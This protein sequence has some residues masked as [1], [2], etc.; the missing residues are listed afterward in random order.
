MSPRPGDTLTAEPTAPGTI[1]QDRDGDRWTLTQPG[2]WHCPRGPWTRTWANLRE[3]SYGQTITLVSTPDPDPDPATAGQWEAITAD[4]VRPGDEVEVTREWD[5][6]RVV[7]TGRVTGIQEYQAWRMLS[8]DR[9]HV[10]VGDPEEWITET[11]RRRVR[12]P[13]PE[14][15]A[16]AVVRHAGHVLVRPDGSLGRDGRP[17]MI[18]AGELGSA[19]NWRTWAEVLALD[20]DTPPVVLDLDAEPTPGPATARTRAADLRATPEPPAS[21]QEPP[22]LG[23]EVT[24]EPC[25]AGPDVRPI[26]T[27]E[28]T[29][30]GTVVED[31]A[32]VWWMRDAGVPGVLAWLNGSDRE[33]WGDLSHPVRLIRD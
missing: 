27:D 20:P 19:S 10:A 6:G 32:G 29:T 24:D 5:S 2:V 30:P 13:M 7:A 14:P 21:T 4:Q 9:C 28:P 18:I 3:R 11:I 12:T 8:L 33:S 23:A 26:L 15:A 31:E 1:V 17:W 22:E 25:A 16:P